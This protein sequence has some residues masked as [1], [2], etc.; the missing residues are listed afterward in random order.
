MA[1]MFGVLHDPT[2]L[3]CFSPCPEDA[4][5]A[6]ERIPGRVEM[7]ARGLAG[8]LCWPLRFARSLRRVAAHLD[9]VAALRALPFVPGAL[10]ERTVTNGHI[11]ALRTAA[12]GSTS[13]SEIKAI[14]D[15]CGATVNDVVMSIVAG[16]LRAW[17]ASCGDLPRG[18]L[19][20]LVPVS[21]RD[22]DS[23][24]EPGNHISTIIARVA[25]EEPDPLR[26]L[27]LTREAMGATKQRQRR[28]PPTVLADANNLIPPILLPAA[29]RLC[30]AAAASRSE[31]AAALVMSNVPGFKDTQYLAG[32]RLLAFHPFSLIFHGLGLNVTV[33]SYGDQLDWG[34][35]GDPA[36]IDDAW[37]LIDALKTAQAE[38]LAAVSPPAAPQQQPGRVRERARNHAQRAQVHALAP[39]KDAKA[40]TPD[41]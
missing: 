41:A 28:M 16:G 37:R 34:V 20:A 38:L 24:S 10:T 25:C 17:L 26:R 4:V 33:V 39:E 3:D 8:L 11:S 6:S 23:M 18:S 21:V 1:G 2:P 30:A 29:T 35:T 13:L 31:A 15:A 36:Q 27:E 14:K 40:A 22:Q 19:A 7:L 32:A 9:Q 5:G 12:F